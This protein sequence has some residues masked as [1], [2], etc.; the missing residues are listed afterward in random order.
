KRG[1]VTEFFAQGF[2]AATAPGKT[3]IPAKE[4]VLP[5]SPV[6]LPAVIGRHETEREI[7]VVVEVLRLNLPR[8]VF[9][10]SA[11]DVEVVVRE[12]LCHRVH[13]G[14]AT[15]AVVQEQ[16]AVAPGTAADVLA[17]AIRRKL[18]VHDLFQVVA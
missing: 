1:A 8:R 10:A 17:N 12:G 9:D 7:R 2:R 6:V 16:A 11:V 13:T 14:V 15:D 5:G 3:R 18:D 4:P